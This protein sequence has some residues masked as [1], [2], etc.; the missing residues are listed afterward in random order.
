MQVNKINGANV[1][2]MIEGSPL[3]Y[4]LIPLDFHPITPN[5]S[6]EAAVAQLWFYTLVKPDAAK[7]Q[8]A[9]AKLVSLF[10]QQQAGG[11][12]RCAGANECLT[13]SHFPIWL[14]A[15]TALTLLIA[16][17][18]NA[19]TARLGTL[20]PWWWE[21]WRALC[22]LGLV[23]SGPLAGSIVLPCARKTGLPGDPSKINVPGDAVCAAAYSISGGGKIGRG[24][25][26]SALDLNPLR[27][28]NAAVALTVRILAGPG[29][30]P[31]FKGGAL[32]KLASRM[33]VLRGSAGHSAS[34]PD[35][36]PGASDAAP[37]VWCE[38]ATGR[39]SFAGDPAPFDH[40]LAKTVTVPGV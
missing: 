31:D 8:A 19:I 21:S 5:Q 2:A 30:G 40:P 38:Y 11:F 24:L 32:P 16:K 1:I 39:F 33:I 37:N 17:F 9:A 13:D 7:A 28:D 27:P 10:E 3:P 15:M 36:M 20:V 34:F 12:M 35:G 26:K 4:A 25:S 22:A 29:F 14:R 18:P 6:L 23:P